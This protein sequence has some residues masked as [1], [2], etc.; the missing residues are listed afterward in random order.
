MEALTGVYTVADGKTR[1][2]CAS[3]VDPDTYGEYRA[4]LSDD[5]F[6]AGAL[7]ASH[8]LEFESGKILWAYGDFSDDVA[9]VG[10]VYT[11][12]YEFTKALI[13][14]PNDKGTA[15]VP[16]SQGRLQL[17]RWKLLVQDSGGFDV[18][19]LSDEI[20]PLEITIAEEPY[21]YSFPSKIVGSGT[22]GVMNPRPVDVF[23]VD[24]GLE[25]QYARIRIVGNSHLPFTLVGAEWEGTYTVRASRV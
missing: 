7:G 10:R 3:D 23:Q 8:N 15:V 22:V 9:R 21:I 13:T 24:V 18:Y 12:V 14:A 5:G 1:W 4:V 11:H 16:V 25:A 19:V 2:T 17:G 20:N 6:A